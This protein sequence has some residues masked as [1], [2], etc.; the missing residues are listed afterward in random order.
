MKGV[1]GCEL[2]ANDDP[3]TIAAGLKRVLTRGGRING[4]ESVLTL[5]EK[6]TTEQVINIYQAA[7]SA[8][9]SATL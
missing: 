9:S 7:L 6:L 5:D 2:C 8:G 1:E 3:E 4:R